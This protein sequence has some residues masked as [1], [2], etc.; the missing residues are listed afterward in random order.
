MDKRKREK[1][2]TKRERERR[3]EEHV[4][5][6]G[7][8]NSKMNYTIVHSHINFLYNGRVILEIKCEIER[9]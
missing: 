9:E 1:K 8:F 5:S 7:P 4:L 3:E 2:K 6:E